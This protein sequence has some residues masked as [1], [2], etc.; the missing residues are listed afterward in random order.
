MSMRFKP[1][2]RKAPWVQPSDGIEPAVGL[3]EAEGVEEWT[4]TA[5]AAKSGVPAALSFPTAVG[6]AEEDIGRML[7]TLTVKRGADGGIR[8]E[9]PAHTAR[10]LMSLFEGMARLLGTAA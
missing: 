4:A 7:G 9:A 3:A 5:D 10:A 8:I 2:R 1:R 6:A